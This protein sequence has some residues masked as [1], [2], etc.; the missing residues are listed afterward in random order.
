MRGKPLRVKLLQG[1]T[2]KQP[3][4]NI[5]GGQCYEHSGPMSSISSLN[6]VPRGLINPITVRPHG[7]GYWLIAGHR[8]DAVKK[9]SIMCSASSAGAR[10]ARMS[11]G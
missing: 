10:S 6:R 1:N 4:K 2:S 11:L 9:P 8:L 7:E 3:E 5:V